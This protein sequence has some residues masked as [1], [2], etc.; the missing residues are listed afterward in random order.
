[1]LTVWPGVW[2]IILKSLKE[3]VYCANTQQAFHFLTRFKFTF[4]CFCRDSPTVGQGLPI[5]EVSR[6][7]T[8]THDSQ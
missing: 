4:V 6:S 3:P 8:T 1:V 5:H 7:H 2:F